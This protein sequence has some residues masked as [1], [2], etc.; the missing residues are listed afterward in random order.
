M[1]PHIKKARLSTNV[2]GQMNPMLMGGMMGGQG[3]LPMMAM[4]PMASMMGAN[5]MLATSMMQASMNHHHH[6]HPGNPGQFHIGVLEEVHEDDD[7]ANEVVEDALAATEED[8]S[9]PGPSDPAM[10]PMGSVRTKAPPSKPVC[11]SLQP[12]QSSKPNVSQGFALS[13]VGD[14]IEEAVAGVMQARRT[15]FQAQKDSMP[16]PRCI[17]HLGGLPKARHSIYQPYCDGFVESER[18]V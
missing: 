18:S 4:N 1:Q 7:G 11:P 17:K 5:P 14:T 3:M 15:L 2:N 13:I 6:H 16:I 10:G 8:E 12:N 9:G